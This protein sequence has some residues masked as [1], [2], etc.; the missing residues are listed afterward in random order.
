MVQLG[1]VGVEPGLSDA[2]RRL[3]DALP[4]AALL[5][6]QATGRIAD[7]N[8]AACQVLGLALHE[9]QGRPL[10]E[11]A[12][13]AELAHTLST[14]AQPLLLGQGRP[15]GLVMLRDASQHQQ[16][17]Q[18]LLAQIKHWR[19]SAFDAVRAQ[20]LERDRIAAGL[21]DEIGQMLAMMGFK[22][23]ELGALV[24]AAAAQ[25]L[26]GELRTLLRQAA[27]AARTAT[28]EL[29]NPVLEQLGLKPALESVAQAIETGRGLRV[30]IHGDAPALAEPQRGVVYRV[31]R[32]LLL[33]VQKHAQATQVTVGLQP[34]GQ[35]SDGELRVEVIDDGRGFDT[36]RAVQRFGPDGGFGLVNARCQMQAVGGTLSL[37][38]APG[39]GTRAEIRLPL[40]GRGG[41]RRGEQGDH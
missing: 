26:V 24:E 36:E 3:F 14:G 21:H 9:L 5:V 35:G 29:S 25:Q 18:A 40:R 41:A 22:L 7:A 28:F 17:E 2:Q 30:R 12:W 11:L 20:A 27:Q 19:Q 39:Q 13:C 4:D 15:H 10:G 34:Q 37:Q 38:S 8:A 33:N 32:E 6:D 1:V 31:L 23:G 16:A